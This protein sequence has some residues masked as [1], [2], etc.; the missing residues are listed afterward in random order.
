M[1]SFL[2]GRLILTQSRSATQ[3]VVRCTAWHSRQRGALKT[4]P[5]TLWPR[6][7]KDQLTH[8]LPVIHTC[9]FDGSM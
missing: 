8:D 3:T 4:I 6:G 2:A 9:P 7:V 5:M 1:S